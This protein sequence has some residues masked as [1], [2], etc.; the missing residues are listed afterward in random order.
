VTKLW[1]EIMPELDVG[2]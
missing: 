1:L 2:P